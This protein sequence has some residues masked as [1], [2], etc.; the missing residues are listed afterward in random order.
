MLLDQQNPQ[1]GVKSQEVL[2]SFATSPKPL[3]NRLPCSYNYKPG[4]VTSS[5]SFW[6]EAR[7]KE[8]PRISA[9]LYEELREQGGDNRRRS[10]EFSRLWLLVL[11]TK[12]IRDGQAALKDYLRSKPKPVKNT[13]HEACLQN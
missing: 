9:S 5:Q 1:T 7:A 11:P 13:G 6:P 3:L 10:R 2:S 8:P 12:R 4:A